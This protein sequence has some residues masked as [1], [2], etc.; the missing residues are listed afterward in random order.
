MTKGPADISEQATTLLK[1]VAADPEITDNPGELVAV[2][3]VAAEA[4]TSVMNHN[5]QAASV[6]E[7]I[8]NFRR[9]S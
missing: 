7:S 1:L 3:R 8:N 2:L 4:A 9:G 5:V 6:D